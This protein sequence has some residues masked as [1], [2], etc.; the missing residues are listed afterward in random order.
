MYSAE[1]L[2]PTSST[3]SFGTTAFAS[4]FI[5]MRLLA[6]ERQTGTL[7]LLTSSPVHDWEIVLGKYLS[8][9]AFLAIV[10]IASV[11]IPALIMVNGKVS[12][13]HLFAGYLGVLLV[14]SATLAIG[15]FGSALARNQI[16]AA[17]FSGDHHAGHAAR[18]PAGAGDRPPAQ[19]HVHGAGA[20]RAA[21]PALPD[22]R[23]SICVTSSTTSR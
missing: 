9:L 13:G 18:A 1:V 15:V 21:L 10:T 19:G 11:Y 3:I 20:V 7:V 23:P 6:E 4:V 12:F 14:G 17:I 16:L 22:G 8:A 2:S 5:S